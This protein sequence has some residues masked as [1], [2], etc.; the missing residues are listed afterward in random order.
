MKKGYRR[1][2]ACATPT[3]ATAAAS[4]ATAAASKRPD[5]TLV[6][7]NSIAATPL[8]N[9]AIMAVPPTVLAR[10]SGSMTSV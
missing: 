2:I 3:K 5:E 4:N 10:F 9:A 7:A 1:K 8:T 6:N